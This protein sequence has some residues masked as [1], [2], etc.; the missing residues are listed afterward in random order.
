MRLE[1]VLCNKRSHCSE[2]PAHTR[3]PALSNETLVQSKKF[4]ISLKKS[5][6]FLLF[7][8]FLLLD[9]SRKP[10]GLTGAERAFCK[11]IPRHPAWN[12]SAISS[13]GH[14][15]T[16]EGVARGMTV[17]LG[18]GLSHLPHASTPWDLPLV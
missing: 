18:E 5:R 16:R 4:L 13:M 7:S 2:K 17:S 12:T 8:S 3:E 15:Y 11:H 14:A 6:A 9:G 1:P 10:R